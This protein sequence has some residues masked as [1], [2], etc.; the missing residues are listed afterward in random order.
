VIRFTAT[1]GRRQLGRSCRFR[2]K[3]GH[4]PFLKPTDKSVS[5]KR[6]APSSIAQI[7]AKVGLSADAAWWSRL[8]AVAMQHEHIPVDYL[9]VRL[10]C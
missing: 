5:T 2:A 1:S 9:R 4:I 7:T 3:L 10:S 6:S 8:P